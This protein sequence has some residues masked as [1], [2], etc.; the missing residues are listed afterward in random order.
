MTLEGEA[1]AHERTRILRENARRRVEVDPSLYAPD[2]PAES[3]AIAARERAAEALLA[4]S[5]SLPGPG[6]RCLEVGVGT[7]G[8]LPTLERWG[9]HPGDQLGFD[10]DVIRLT[11]ARADHAR[12]GFSVA[13]AARLPLADGALDLVVAST[14]LSSILDGAVQEAVAQEIVRTLKPGGALVL[15]DLRVDNP[16]NPHVRGLSKA[17]VRRLFAPLVGEIRSITLAPPL[18]RRLLPRAPGA[19]RLLEAVPWLRSHVLAVLRKP[20]TTA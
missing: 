1:V 4:R 8:W 5:G 2:A 16:R 17:H 3:V 10:L 13:D 18:A 7:R 19:A 14:V 9:V 12:V 11:Q 15:Y 20:E 6:H